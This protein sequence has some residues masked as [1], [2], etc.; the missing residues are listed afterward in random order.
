MI[1]YNL[2]KGLTSGTKLFKKNDEYRAYKHEL[3]NNLLA[4]KSIKNK[5]TKEFDSS[6]DEIISLYNTK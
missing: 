3:L 1:R 6:L 2:K 4:L 5:N